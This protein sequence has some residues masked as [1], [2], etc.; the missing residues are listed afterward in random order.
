MP[1][2]HG[3]CTVSIDAYQTIAP[4]CLSQ[5]DV[6]KDAYN[7][8]QE[9]LAADGTFNHLPT[10][11]TSSTRELLGRPSARWI[12]KLGTHM[13]THLQGW[14]EQESSIVPLDHPVCRKGPLHVALWI[15]VSP[16]RLL[17]S[18]HN[19]LFVNTGAATSNVPCPQTLDLLIHLLVCRPISAQ[20]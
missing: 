10:A 5:D 3:T 18:L 4:H 2:A 19:T 6:S 9:P 13:A 14:V 17:T 16:D 1:G 12:V 11:R 20:S 7:D 15:D 8:M